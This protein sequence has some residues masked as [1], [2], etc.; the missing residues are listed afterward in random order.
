MARAKGMGS[1][2]WHGGKWRARWV[3]DGQTFTRSTGETNEAK[4]R[5]ALEAFVAPFRLRDEAEAAERTARRA[6]ADGHARTGADL[7]HESRAKRERA[8]ALVAFP[9]ADAW[10]AYA[11][12]LLHREW[13]P[14]TAALN[15]ARV[16]AFV[17]WMA[18][19]HP[20]IRSARDVRPE[21][22]QAFL[23]QLRRRATGKTFNDYRAILLQTWTALRR[24]PD[25]GVESNPFDGVA[26]AER[27]SHARRE[28][29]VEELASVL[30][31]SSGEMRR[32]FAIGIYTGLRLGDAATLQWAAV[33]LERGFVSVRP[34]KTEHYGT[35]VK[36]P[37]APVLSR[38]LEETPERRRKGP[39]VPGL[40][41]LYLSG[42]A[43]EKKL[44]RRIKRV[45][46]AAGIE[47]AAQGEHR[48]A[49]D[50]GFHSLRH[51]YVSLCANA[52]VPLAIVQAIVGH[53]SV[54]MTE[55][56][57]HAEDSAL[58]GAAAALPDVTGGKALP[59][60]D[61]L[62]A[63]RAAVAALKPEQMKEAGRILKA[64]GGLT[65]RRRLG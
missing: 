18:A 30:A 15:A 19:A 20:D 22:A 41:A 8:A 51:T 47:T 33:D 43:G 56:Y 32:L 29:S 48:K 7:R 44:H 4:A 25:S 53:T 24:L 52:G 58:R 5:K 28:L 45:F 60:P 10:R 3:V 9:L 1:L 42:V 64:A 61:G 46:R 55:H 37:L 49:V 6:E 62:A 14:K 26:R 39:V 57:F 59:P 65:R 54:A 50:V 21:H 40:A 36:I 38:V 27:R 23:R 35:R 11:D 2:E 12:S 16:G 13:T 34:R 17:D 63:F 31:C